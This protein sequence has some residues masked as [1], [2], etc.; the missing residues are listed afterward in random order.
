MIYTDE[1]VIAIRH[2]AI[3]DLINKGYMLITNRYDEDDG[4]LR[5]YLKK[6]N[7]NDCYY[8]VSIYHEHKH[9]LETLLP[10]KQYH[11]YYE[12]F[13]HTYKVN[14]RK[15][16]YKSAKNLDQLLLC[17]IHSNDV[18]CEDTTFK[19]LYKICEDK[20]VYTDD[21]EE[22]YTIW[23]KRADRLIESLKYEKL[24]SR[25]YEFYLEITKAK[26]E[27]IDSIM[28]VIN[29]I[30]GWT[31]VNSKCIKCIKLYKFE[32]RLY[33]CVTVEN[34]YGSHR[35]IYYRTRKK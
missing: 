22:L 32:K 35:S 2:E 30:P 6:Q 5:V 33:G 13:I 15:V 18:I 19:V 23:K 21:L 10:N 34:C 20:K 29:K 25:F 31:N 9:S 3:V 27:L 11:L 24:D 28:D 8:V 17:N 1:Q 14:V 7:C 12:T 26:P 16:V 4:K